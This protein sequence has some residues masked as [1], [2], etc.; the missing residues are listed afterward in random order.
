MLKRFL[1]LLMIVVTAAAAFPTAVSAQGIELELDCKA[2][3]LMEADTGEV[4]YSSNENERLPEA[5]ITK[6]MTMLLVFEALDSGVISYSDV[7]ACSEY[8]ASMGGS[9]I[10]LEPGEEMTVYDLIKAAMV[11]SAN[12]ASVVLAEKIAGTH[13][14]FVAMMNERAQQLGMTQ[15]AYKNCTGLDAEGHLTSAYDV[16]IVSRELL[17]HERVRGFSTIWMD[18]LR[19]GELGLTNTNKLVRYYDG[20]TGLK[21]GTT[22]QAGCCV[23]ATAE[24]DG[25]ELI[26]VVMG[27]PNSKTRFSCAQKLLDYGFAGY[28]LADLS[29]MDI[30]TK[31]IPVLSGMEKSVGTQLVMEGSVLVPKGRAGDIVTQVNIAKDVCA[32]VEQG[33]TVG[34]ISVYL[35]GKL[36]GEFNITT[37]HSVGKITFGRIFYIMLEELLKG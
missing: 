14:A 11:G 23:A 27:A 5:S 18:S 26:A 24:R 31:P 10:W 34:T 28:E 36:L 37:T 21:T 2:C 35:D 30:K 17:R 16:A 8:A 13:E 9:Q 29:Q 25:M 1:A 15:T 19:N 20:C 3:V 7:V 12:D 4:L 32:P 33:Q 22:S 6:V